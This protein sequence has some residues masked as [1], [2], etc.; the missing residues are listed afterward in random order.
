[1][2]LGHCIPSFNCE[3]CFG[4]L[5]GEE[6]KADKE[7]T[8]GAGKNCFIMFTL[9][10]RTCTWLGIYVLGEDL[11]FQFVSPTHGNVN[12]CSRWLVPFLTQVNVGSVRHKGP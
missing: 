1:M 5:C 6:I 2:G 8:W 12:L 9:P 10:E 7:N 11:N 3:R 4:E